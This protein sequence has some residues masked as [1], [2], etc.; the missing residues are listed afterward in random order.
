MKNNTILA[1]ITA[2]LMAS[3]SASTLANGSVIEPTNDQVATPVD[4]GFSMGIN[5]YT[6]IKGGIGLSVGYRLP[7]SPKWAV[8]PELRFVNSTNMSS[9]VSKD[10]LYT[11]IVKIGEIPDLKIFIVFS[12]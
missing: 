8:M 7:L 1:A 6:R 4:S 3:A 5:Y 12:A 11:F 9:D 2:L 10:Y